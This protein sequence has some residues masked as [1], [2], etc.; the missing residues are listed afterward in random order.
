MPNYYDK[1]GKP[2]EL[3]EWALLLKQATYEQVANT[4]LPDGKWVSTIWLGFNRRR[5]EGPPLIFETMVFQSRDNLED[6]D[7]ARYSTLAEAEA[8]HI[9]VVSKWTLKT[10]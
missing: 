5:D 6:L 8:G 1:E 3:M 9:A 4:I 10:G 2:L 7:C